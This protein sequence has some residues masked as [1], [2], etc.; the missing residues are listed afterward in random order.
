V[1]TTK[2]ALTIAVTKLFIALL[3][4]YDTLLCIAVYCH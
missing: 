2:S 4:S 3:C 1:L